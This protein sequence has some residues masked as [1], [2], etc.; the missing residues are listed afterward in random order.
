[1]KKVSFKPLGDRVLVKRI[2]AKQS[3]LIH[4]VTSEKPME[5]EVIAVG[6]GSPMLLNATDAGPGFI[7][8]AVKPGDKVLIGKYNGYEVEIDGEPYVVLREDEILGVL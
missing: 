4:I 8:P 7:R 3:G 6:P 2:E 5:A 1:M